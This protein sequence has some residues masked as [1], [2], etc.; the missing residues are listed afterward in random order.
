MNKF[1]KW[2][3]RLLK[4]KESPL[5]KSAQKILHLVPIVIKKRKK[6]ECEAL[7]S[8]WKRKYCNYKAVGK[9]KGS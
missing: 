2:F 4:A 9:Q 5:E 6:L 8:E 1:I 3:Y 7:K